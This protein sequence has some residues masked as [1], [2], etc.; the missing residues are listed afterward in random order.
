MTNILN[1]NESEIEIEEPVIER[2][3]V[4]LDREMDQGCVNYENREN[5]ILDQLKLDHL[6]SKERKLLVEKC[7]T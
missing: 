3:E 6:N 4:D 2:E 1:T 5:V 7:L